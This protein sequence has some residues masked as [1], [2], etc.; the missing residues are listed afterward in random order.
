MRHS[1][2]KI[3][4]SRGKKNQGGSW[5]KKKS[6]YNLN[7]LQCMNFLWDWYSASI[8]KVIIPISYFNDAFVFLVGS[9]YKNTQK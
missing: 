1:D 8:L 4:Y 9:F 6:L 2:L 5:G 3:T 7:M